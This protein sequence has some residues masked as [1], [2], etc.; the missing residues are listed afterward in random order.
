MR[1]W[2]SV[3]GKQWQ[4]STVG[5]SVV[6]ST[7]TESNS[8]LILCDQLE[9]LTCHSTHYFWAEMPDD[10]VSH[11]HFLAG[12]LMY[13]NVRT[14]N[15]SHLR[16]PRLSPNL[17]AQRCLYLSATLVSHWRQCYWKLLSKFSVES[18]AAEN[19]KNKKVFLRGPGR[20]TPPPPPCG[21][22]NT[23]ENSTFPSHYV[24]EW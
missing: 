21:Q 7:P 24:C 16:K 5:R 11:F 13:K 17:T 12:L 10:K 4:I 3:T 19:R 22:T 1:V 8:L 2:K 6:S 9:L 15:L 20:G 18:V 14:V 23:C